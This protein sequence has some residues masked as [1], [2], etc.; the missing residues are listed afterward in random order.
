MLVCGSRSV[1]PHTS[2]I[3]SRLLTLGDRITVVSGGARGA[4]AAAEECAREYGFDLE[5]HPADW[6]RYGKRAGFIRNVEMLDSGVDCVLA[7]WDGE[8]RGTAHTVAQAKRRG[9]KVWVVR[10]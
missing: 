7:F 1:T 10:C 6:T 4:D 8:S 2:E 5:V 9:I 3:R